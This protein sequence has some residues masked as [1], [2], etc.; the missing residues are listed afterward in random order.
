MP[1]VALLPLMNVF[2]S[3]FPQC[4]HKH[5]SLMQG[6]WKEQIGKLHPS[7]TGCAHQNGN[8]RCEDLQGQLAVAFG[9]FVCKE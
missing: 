1:V 6:L 4:Q 3:Y 5:D 8:Q 2:G 7:S 9:I